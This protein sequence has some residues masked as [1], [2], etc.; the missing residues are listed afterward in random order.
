MQSPICIGVHAVFSDNAYDKII[1]SGAKSV[2]T[3]NTIE[4]MSNSIDVAPL[5]ADYLKKL[6]QSTDKI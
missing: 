2:V 3:C 6:H 1:S 4:H 5:I